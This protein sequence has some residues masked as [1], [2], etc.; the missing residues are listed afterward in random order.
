MNGLTGRF[1]S[2]DPLG[3][4]SGSLLS[5][6][7]VGARCLTRRDPS[8]LIALDDTKKKPYIEHPG[9]TNCAGFAVHPEQVAID[10]TGNLIDFLEAFG[11]GKCTLGGTASQCLKKCEEMD[12]VQVYAYPIPGLDKIPNFDMRSELEK[13]VPDF[14]DDYR[15]KDVPSMLL[16]HWAEVLKKL[17]DQGFHTPKRFPLIDFHFL[18]CRGPEFVYQKCNARFG[19]DGSGKFP[20]DNCVDR[21]SDPLIYTP[22]KDRPEFFDDSII[23]MKLCCCKDVA[24]KEDRPTKAME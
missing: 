5:Y 10:V 19:S 7:Y 24:K 20:P 8:G 1:L 4:K 14:A 2:R 3:F 12:C 21:R 22:S 16:Y 11:Y 18:K 17:E 23:F 6:G 15:V 9:E 13:L